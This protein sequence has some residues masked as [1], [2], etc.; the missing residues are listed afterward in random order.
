MPKRVEEGSQVEEIYPW[1]LEIP[2][3]V[4]RIR[5]ELSSE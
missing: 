4:P 5:S 1:W 2:R 3:L